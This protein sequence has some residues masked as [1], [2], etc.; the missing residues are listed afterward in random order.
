MLEYCKY[1][2]NMSKYK[3]SK[4]AVYKLVDDKVFL[5]DY[6]TATIHEL[7]DSAS[8]IWN[9]LTNKSS[10]NQIL[11]SMLKEFDVDESIAKS[12]I[13]DFITEY[14]EKGYIV[15]DDDKKNK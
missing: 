9:S 3:I 7:N 4:K 5:L 2:G 1:G 11:K 10:K 8:Y 14:S 12:D 15:K 6:K 13:D